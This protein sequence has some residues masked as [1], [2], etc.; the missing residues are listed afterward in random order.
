VTTAQDAAPGPVLIVGPP[1]SGTSALA[2]C[3][4]N[5]GV[6]MG[7]SFDAPTLASPTSNL[8]DRRGRTINDLLMTEATLAR[9]GESRPGNVRKRS[10]W[11]HPNEADTISEAL[12]RLLRAYIRHRCARTIRWGFKDPRLCFTLPLW[13]ERIDKK[14]SIVFTRRLNRRAAALSIARTMEPAQFRMADGRVDPELLAAATKL[15]R[16]YEDAMQKSR[17]RCPY[18]VVDVTFESLFTTDGQRFLQT[19]FFPETSELPID[20]AFRRS[21]RIAEREGL[22]L[23]EPGV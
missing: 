2:G 8:E 5:A 20:P 10:S 23:D 11:V 9:P 6:S 18:P 14:P 3:F 17:L 1:R 4:A 22:E 7:R 13:L 19:T 21:D 12:D 16:S 15:L